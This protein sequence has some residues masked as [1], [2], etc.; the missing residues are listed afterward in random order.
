MRGFRDF[1][2]GNPLSFEYQKVI[3]GQNGTKSPRQDIIAGGFGDNLFLDVQLRLSNYFF[4]FD[5]KKISI[6]I[7]R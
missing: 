1:L 7:N 5:F 3:L 2:S 4:S 6:R